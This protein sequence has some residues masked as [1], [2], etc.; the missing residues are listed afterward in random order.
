MGGFVTRGPDAATR[1]TDLVIDARDEIDEL[2][3]IADRGPGSDA[4]RRAAAHLRRRL[5]AMGRDAEVEATWIR[6]SW[7][8]AHTAYALTGIVA[9]VVSTAA[10]VAGIIAAALAAILL[11]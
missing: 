6:P 4:E 1:N 2:V 7:P 3:A 8:L 11:I 10:P 5:E 9:S